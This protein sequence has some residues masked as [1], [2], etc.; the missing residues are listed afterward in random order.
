MKTVEK[1]VD[2]GNVQSLS[3]VYRLN[4][5]DYQKMGFGERQSEVLIESIDEVK[6]KEVEPAKLLASFGVRGLGNR[7]SKSVLNFFELHEFMMRTPSVEE[8]SNIENFNH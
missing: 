5:E 8:I 4:K 3:D 1:I 7:A 2:S 6:N